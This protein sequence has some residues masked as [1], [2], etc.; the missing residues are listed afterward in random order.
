VQ[1]RWDRL[2][3]DEE[4]LIY[5]DGN[6]PGPLWNGTTWAIQTTPNPTS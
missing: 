6:S 2:E 4:W 1:R 5:R 3:R